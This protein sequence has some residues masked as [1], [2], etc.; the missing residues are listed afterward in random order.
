MK[1][2][3]ILVLGGSGFIGRHIVAELA[4]RV[5]NVTAPTRRRERAKHLILL[6]T[7]QVVEADILEPGVLERHAQGNEAVI[8]LVGV[9]HSR[10]G[11]PNERG[12][13]NYGPG[14]AQ[15][16][17]E[18]AQAAV[19]ACRAA[20]IRRLVHVSAIGAD[21][22]APSEYLRSKAIGEQA[23]IAAGDLDVTVFRPSVVFGP[24]DQF[25]NR[26]AQLVKLFP[27]IG[28]PRANARFQ[29]VYVG[30]VARAVVDCLDEP[31]TY[32]QRYDLAGPREYSMRELFDYVCHATG[33]HRFLF[34]LP[35]WMAE[36]QA[37]FLELSPVPI[38]SRDNLR[39]MDVPST[40]KAPFPFG[41][42]PQSLEAI[43][44]T[45]LAP[46][47]PRERLPE[48]RWRARR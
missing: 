10:R 35:D 24:E 37:R 1:L 47:G 39:S 31:V 38:M 45:Y 9:L 27:V 40:T 44:P 30:D 21:S 29:P 16:H 18:V 22:R 17:V 11:R 32:G 5:M 20:G 28:I 36:S 43:A 6:P 8:N 34:G 46:H 41:M 23:V 25:L 3:N 48:L 13:N 7:V 14:F 12:P 15:A 42:K 26:F 2:K 4:R 33:R 19:R